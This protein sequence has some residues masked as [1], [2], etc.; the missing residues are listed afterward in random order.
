MVRHRYNTGEAASPKTEPPVTTIRTARAAE[1]R[2]T[3]LANT[4]LR[5]N[6]L[7]LD[8]RGLI[9]YMLSLPP[10]TRFTVESLTEQVPNGRD[11]VR[12]MLREAEKAGYFAR[13]RYQ[14]KG[15]F[16]CWEQIISDAPVENPAE[17][18]DGKP[19]D[20]ATSGNSASSQVAPS[21][22]NPSYGEPAHKRSKTVKSK[23]GN[24]SSRASTPPANRPAELPADMTTLVI[25]EIQTQTGETI[26]LAHAARVVAQILGRAKS[27]PANPAA[28][29]LTSIRREPDPRVFLPT[30]TPPPAPRRRG[31]PDWDAAM[32]RATTREQRE[33]LDDPVPFGAVLPGA[34]VA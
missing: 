28:F 16:W 20:G 29:V 9:A 22:G 12:R 24:T 4:M 7:S 26:P 17:P 10:D 34:I 18:Y 27:T 1:G 3:Q 6:Q 2:F 8:T 13:R 32:A 30:P 11:A 21:A 25:D 23:D 14:D 5:D 31:E 33:H 15:G 19:A